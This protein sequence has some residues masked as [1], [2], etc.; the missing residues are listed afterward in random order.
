MLTVEQQQDAA[1]RTSAHP[2]AF[3]AD[4]AAWT[5]QSL[6][7]K[8]GWR[9]QL[10][11]RQVSDLVDL[12]RRIDQKVQGDPNGLLALGPEDLHLGAAQELAEH[13]RDEL[14]RGLGLCLIKGIP[15]EELPLLHSAIIYWALGRHLGVA[16]SNNPDGDMLGHV[17]DTG[18]DVSQPNHRGYQ[19]RAGLDYHCD[20][21]SIVGLFCVKTPKSGGMSK[22]V[23]SIEVYNRILRDAPHLLDVLS[24]PY[25]WSL[26]G[27]VNPGEKGYFESPV[28]NFLDGKLCVSFGPT[29]MIKGHKVAGAPPM[30]EQ[31][32]NALRYMEDVCESLQH[33]MQME[34]GDIQLLN[35]GVCLH[36]R[37][38]YE[39]WPQPDRKRH[40]WR[41]WL[42]APH[43]RART[44]YQQRYLNGVKLNGT[45]ERITLIP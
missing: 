32:M 24:R 15:A 43:M 39:D 44:A 11:D 35:N 26:H 18:K 27:E 7:A 6:S 45:Q 16:L 34:V 30:S 3:V 42:D 13:I 10:S 28:F 23:S 31:Q 1:I 9:C 40:L 37:T 36:T 17:T 12:S 22:V 8:A 33:S 14:D 5:P 19:T 25:C 2:G 21:S 38:E 41:L 29:H 4:P 20:T